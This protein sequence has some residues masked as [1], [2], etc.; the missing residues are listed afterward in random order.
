MSTAL[1]RRPRLSA[2]LALVAALAALAA[3]AVPGTALADAGF[4][5]DRGAWLRLG[6]GRKAPTL[7]LDGRLHADYAQYTEDATP[8]ADGFLLRRLRPGLT[9]SWG[10]W[11]G[12]VEY[13]F[14]K[15]SP[16]LRAAWIE[17]DGFKRTRLRAG[18]Q[19]VPFGLEASGSSNDAPFMERS[20]ASVALAPGNL[21]GLMVRKWDDRWNVSIGGYANDIADDEQRG[22]D[23]QGL[24]LRMVGQPYAPKR[25][26]FQLGVSVEA[27]AASGAGELRYRSRPES[28]V[29]GSRLVDTG[30]VDGVDA[31]ITAAAEA[32]WQRGSVWLGGEYISAKVVRRD[33]GSLTFGGWQATG[34]W[35]ITGEKRD[36]TASTGAFGGVKPKRRWGALELKVRAS[37]LDLEDGTFSGGRERNE[38][39]GL[40]YWYSEN[41]RV[42]AEYIRIH[43]QPGADGVVQDPTVIQLRVQVAL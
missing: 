5:L 10:D 15:R 40:N 18:N 3:L 9:L 19:P 25:T 30:R 8:L 42:L 28:N 12:K 34:S 31:L 6:E 2:G 16:G 7:T 1:S 23:G 22:L 17:Y 29:D 35:F 20:T 43:A 41:I 21:V 24:I 37:E 27:R 14:A 39:A 11:R 4:S 32:A 38:A 13:E 36:F 33:L 26:R